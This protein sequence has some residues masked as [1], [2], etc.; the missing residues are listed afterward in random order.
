LSVFAQ[1]QEYAASDNGRQMA[2]GEDRMADTVR[3]LSGMLAVIG[4]PTMHRHHPAPA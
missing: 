2:A 3:L 4:R 1:S